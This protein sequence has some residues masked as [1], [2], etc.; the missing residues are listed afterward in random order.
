MFANDFSQ[1]I[2]LLQTFKKETS[3]RHFLILMLDYD[4]EISKLTIFLT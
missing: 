2:L 4:I 3:S 1:F